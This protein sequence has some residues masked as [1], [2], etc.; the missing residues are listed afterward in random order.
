VTP[1][2]LSFSGPVPAAIAP[3]LPYLRDC[4]NSDTVLSPSGWRES[5]RVGGGGWLAVVCMSSSN[6]NRNHNNGRT[7]FQL[8]VNAVDGACSPDRDSYRA[9]GGVRLT[10]WAVAS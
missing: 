1:S 5:A 9:V 10:G 7:V 8:D 2:W 4:A 6:N 3:V